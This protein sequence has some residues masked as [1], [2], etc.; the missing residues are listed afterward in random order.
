MFNGIKKYLISLIFNGLM[1]SPDGGETIVFNRYYSCIKQELI[2]Y[3]IFF[4]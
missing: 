2:I 4:N 3:Q 1:M